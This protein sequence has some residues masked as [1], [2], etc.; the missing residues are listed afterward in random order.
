VDALA[1]DHRPLLA[2]AEDFGELFE[3]EQSDTDCFLRQ[4]QILR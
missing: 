3:N 4:D 1:D 2:I